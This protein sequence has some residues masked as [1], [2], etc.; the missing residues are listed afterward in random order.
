MDKVDSKLLTKKE[1]L[2]WANHLIKRNFPSSM[3]NFK[4]IDDFANGVGFCYLLDIF[5]PGK[6]KLSKLNQKAK[7]E[8]ENLANLKIL[9][10]AMLDAG[11]E[12]KFEVINISF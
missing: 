10:T 3:L 7:L 1:L 4:S 11:I 8:H 6:V 9:T 5:N 2:S 12:K